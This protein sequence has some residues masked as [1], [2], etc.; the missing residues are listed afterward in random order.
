ME[1]IHQNLYWIVPLA[2][3]LGFL[4]AAFIWKRLPPPEVSSSGQETPPPEQPDAETVQAVPAPAAPPA[5]PP[6]PVTEPEPSAPVREEPATPD[7]DG[8]LKRTRGI[9]ARLRS[10][11]AGQPAIGPSTWDDLEELL[12]TADIGVKTTEALI[13]QVRAKKP[14]D[15]DAVRQ[16]LR[17]AILKILETVEHADP[18]QTGLKPRVVMIAGVNGVGKTTTIGKIAHHYRKAGLSLMLGAADT[19]R[20]AAVDQLDVWCQRTGAEIVRGRENADPSGVAYESVEQAKKRGMDVLIVDTAG[21]LHTATNL[22]E[23]LKKVKRVIGKAMEGAPHEVWLVVDGTTGQNAIS[24]VRE[25]HQ[26]LAL[27]GL[28]V[29]KLDGTSKGGALISIVNE[30]RLPVRYI[31]VGERLA[32]LTP[33][34]P[35]RFVSEIFREGE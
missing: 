35:G 14:K 29:T 20:A 21:R 18:V 30:F 32:D 33:F 4:A 11:L 19:F 9:F 3:A 2:L 22:M 7:Y 28:I 12:I 16:E 31:G 15:P 34:D 10:I 24:Q 26:A 27:T 13:S 17:V 25:F 1:F 5:L 8:G 6:S 23:E